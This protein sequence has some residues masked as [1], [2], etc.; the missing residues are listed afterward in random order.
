MVYLTTVPVA[1]SARPLM[2]YWLV[3]NSLLIIN[4]DEIMTSF[5]VFIL[6]LESNEENESPWSF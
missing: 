3:N 6:N 4:K 1:E 2:L 5:E